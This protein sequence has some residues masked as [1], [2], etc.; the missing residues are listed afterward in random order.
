MAEIREAAQD[1]E[2]RLHAEEQE[3]MVAAQRM[4]EEYKEKISSLVVDLD[5]EIRAIFD[6]LVEKDLPGM[7]SRS[8]EIETDLAK[9][10]T[11]RVP[12]EINSQSGE[13]NSSIV[14]LPILV[15]AVG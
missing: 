14:R 6:Q 10:F 1:F 11:T 8:E 15:H 13:V 5:R 4:E 7:R 2:A 9:F 3:V 12:E